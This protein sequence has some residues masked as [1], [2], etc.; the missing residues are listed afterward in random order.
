MRVKEFMRLVRVGFAEELFMDEYASESGFVP[1]TFVKNGVEYTVDQN[2]DR[3]IITLTSMDNAESWLTN[4]T[5]KGSITDD[6]GI[7]SFQITEGSTTTSVDITNGSWTYNLISTDT[8]GISLSF[9]TK[10]FPF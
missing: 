7:S 6:D 8:Q 5:L 1:Q 10:I 2:T 3:P 9:L 4:K